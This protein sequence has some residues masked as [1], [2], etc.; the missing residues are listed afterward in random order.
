MQRMLEQG[1][2][3][4]RIAPLHGPE[5][6][7]AV[8]QMFKVEILEA[9]LERAK[10]VLGERWRAALETEGIGAPEAGEAV[11]DAGA[12]TVC[13]AC[14]HKFVAKDSTTAECPECGLFLGVPA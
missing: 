1:S 5:D 6:A 4:S 7:P 3:V 13:P 8:A 12:E 14:G 9:D 2:V 10:Q 11:L